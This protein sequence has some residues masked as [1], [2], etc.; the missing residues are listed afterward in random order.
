MPV[1]FLV[2]VVAPPP[3]TTPPDVYELSDAACT[4]ITVGQPFTSR[5]IATNYCGSS[6]TITDIA[7]L[8]FPGMIKSSLIRINSTTYYK[9]V[10]WTPTI[11]QLG[12][13]VMCAMAIDR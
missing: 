13:Q 2:N 11:D 4:A 1:Q 5:V 7:T 12:Y 9:T 3:C 10:V 6:V 8:S